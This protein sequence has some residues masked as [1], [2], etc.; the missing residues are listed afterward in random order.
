MSN[1]STASP[2]EPHN[3]TTK[4]PTPPSN[5]TADTDAMPSAKLPALPLTLILAATPSLGIGQGGALPWP[6]LK[7]EMG[8]FARVT[9][10]VPPQPSAAISGPSR[11]VNAVVMGRK[12]WDSIPERFRPLKGRVNVVI[13][14]GVA[15][16]R[17]T[18]TTGAEKNASGGK[19]DVD[20][21]GPIIAPSISAA[22]SALRSSDLAAR[23]VHIERVFVIGGASIYKV[24]LDLPQTDKV[25][26]TKIKTEF[27]CDTYF[28]LDLNKEREWKLAGRERLE[29]F[30]GEEVEEGGVAEKGVGFEFCLYEKEVVS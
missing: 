4:S 11:R 25:L 13:T 27:E 20:F 26:L 23:N 8:Y 18:T 3:L 10:R 2:P 28:P 5:G 19:E 14:R 7:K 17:W 21:E 30:V 1:P 6:Q 24:A 9:K 16:V 12:T 29:E 15:D 22:L